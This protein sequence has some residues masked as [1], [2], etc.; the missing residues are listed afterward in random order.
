MISSCAAIIGVFPSSF[1]GSIRAAGHAADGTVA[2][3]YARC[4]AIGQIT[5]LLRPVA[6]WPQRGF[7]VSPARCSR[8]DSGVP[9]G[10][11]SSRIGGRRHATGTAASLAWDL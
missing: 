10:T 1:D 5:R 8:S 7:P 9:E 11:L 3:A 4:A 6:D 2:A